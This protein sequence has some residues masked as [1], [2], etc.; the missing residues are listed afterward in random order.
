MNRKTT[1]FYSKVGL[2]DQTAPSFPVV[3][4]HAV[5]LAGNVLYV[6]G[7]ELLNYASKSNSVMEASIKI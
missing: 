6:A 5:S 2:S 3:M 1:V 7:Y 4:I